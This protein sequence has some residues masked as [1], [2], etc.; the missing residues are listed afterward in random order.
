MKRNIYTTLLFGIL[1]S[2]VY[3]QFIENH[4]PEIIPNNIHGQLDYS[5][6]SLLDP[7]RF[8]IQQGFS[9]SM[10]SLGKQSVSVAGY[11][12]N[13]TYWANDNL[14]LNA[15]ILLYQ[16]SIN[17]FNN[18]GMQNNGPRIAFDLSLIHI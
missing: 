11:T 3:P 7:Q 5:S 9:M 8:D 4:R 10:M 18:Q 17:S 16:P 6:I 15:N 2:A 1:I 12:N 13:I 14:R